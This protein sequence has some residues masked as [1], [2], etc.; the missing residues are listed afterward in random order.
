M[1]LVSNLSSVVT[2]NGITVDLSAPETGIVTDGLEVDQYWTNSTTDLILSWSGFQ[3]TT[4]GIA[5]FQL[6]IG[7][8]AGAN[9]V[10]PWVDLDTLITTTQTGLSLVN[11]G[12]YFGNIKAVDGVGNIATTVS[13][14]GITVDAIAPEITSLIEADLSVDWDYQGS[15]STFTIVWSGNDAASGID[16]YEYA[17]GTDP[18]YTDV[19]DW[20]LAYL[21]T[22]VTID[23]LLLEEHRDTY[24]GLVRATDLA[25]NTS[26]AFSGDG[27]EVDI[28]PP[29]P[30]TV[31][32][33]TNDDLVFTGSDTALTATWEGYSD[34]I[35]G[36]AYYEYAIGLS[37]GE[38]DVLPWVNNAL[39]TT[40]FVSDL[41][42][43]LSLI[44]I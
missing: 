17:L 31:I 5:N 35:S 43:D 24:Y 25:G 44:H 11:G 20:T 9:N 19:V 22:S 37:A 34:A 16:Y 10:L 29:S 38:D 21:N 8:V 4:S 14:N 41:D 30:G 27:V 3:D 7:T 18:S 42:L 36:I 28:S 40:I 26:A 33:G 13:S 2:T 39:D 15:D 32:D 1:D 23:S 12:T 6:S